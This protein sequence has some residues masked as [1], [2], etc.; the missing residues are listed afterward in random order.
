MNGSHESASER[1]PRLS[2]Q[3]GGATGPPEQPRLTARQLAVAFDD[4]ADSS[5]GWRT[6]QLV[7][8]TAIIALMIPVSAAT[9]HAES[10]YIVILLS[11][12][13]VA[14]FVGWSWRWQLA[15]NLVTLGLYVVAQLAAPPSPETTADR[16]LGIIAALI[17]AQLIVVLRDRNRQRV[18]RQLH[19]LAEA[20]DFRETQIATMTHDIRSPLAT[21][22]GI[23][24][25]LA[26]SGI[27]D[28]ER[29]NLM[30]RLGATTASMDLIVKNMLDLYMLDEGHMQPFRRTV[31]A[32]TVVSETAERYG[33]EAR[34]RG[35]KL[36]IELG[37]VA[38]A[39]LD[40]LHL[41]R[42]V[43][44]L[45]T[46]A[47]RRTEAGEVRI[48]TAQDDGWMTLEVSDTG[49]MVPPVEVEHIFERPNLSENGTRAAAFGRY[50]ARALVESAGGQVMARTGDGWGLSLIVRLPIRA[51]SA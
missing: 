6:G 15:L 17:L 27:D 50:I 30:A 37:G 45:V 9:R 46:S 26:E 44:N 11:P 33:S 42:I 25:L 5:A 7:V 43:A 34:L 47:I 35:L 41:E 20:A 24:S 21:L 19:Q 22:I 3:T 10:G 16:A 12:V 29:A 49:L 51:P 18:K 28:A 23:A 31:S 1:D 40:P 38:Q 14:T 4:V 39:H 36:A 2:A 32:D 48:R 13:A 8:C